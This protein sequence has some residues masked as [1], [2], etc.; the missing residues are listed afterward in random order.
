MLLARTR[1]PRLLL[2][3]P[4][5][6][7]A[8]RGL[9]A[10]GGAAQPFMLSDIGEGIAEVEITRWFVK[11]GDAVQEFDKLCEV[12]S[13][14]ATVEISSPFDGV[15]ESL[16]Y[17]VG[18]IAKTGHPLLF[19]ARDG[20]AD[21]EEP[22]AAVSSAPGAPGAAGDRTSGAAAAATSS[23]SSTAAAAAA[24]AE[25]AKVL[26]TPATRAIARQHGIELAAVA[27][28]GRDGRVTKDDVRAHIAGA[29]AATATAPLATPPPVPQKT[30]PAAEDRSEPIRGI[31]R[32]MFAQMT[33]ANQARRG[34]CRAI[35][36]P[37]PSRARAI[38]LVRVETQV[39][40]FGY[41]DEVRMDALAAA[42]QELKAV[43]AAHGLS[44]FTLMPLIVKATSLALAEYPT[45]NSSVSDDGTELIVKA[46]HN[47]GVAMD[48]PTGEI[49]AVACGESGE[50]GGGGC[51]GRGLRAKSPSR[52][53]HTGR[54]PR[55]QRQG[56]WQS[57]SSR[58]GA[59]ACA[60]AGTPLLRAR[61]EARTTKLSRAALL[62]RSR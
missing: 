18:A 40:H 37:L 35:P 13:D 55:A 16:A 19:I 15:I 48:T 8:I 6:S 12:Q 41:C 47:I 54:A 62:P 58:G 42:R 9:A 61:H 27:G 38:Q 20:A 3:R 49:G 36:A 52:P 53:S 43:A 28:T 59:R 32:A 29:P 11:P 2:G 14:K 56:C 33:A 34:P 26:A 5:P 39:P 4:L 17:D 10:S 23:A 44:K 30:A 24:A 57:L 50:V 60:V 22:A 1:L 45:L 21:A 31:R 51:P 46:A 7:L 25:G